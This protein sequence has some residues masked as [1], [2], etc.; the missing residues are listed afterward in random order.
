MK[1]YDLRRFHGFIEVAVDGVFHH[2]AQFLNGLTL[3]MDAV[4]ERM[5]V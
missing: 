4:T 3:R 5:A 2:S 1:P